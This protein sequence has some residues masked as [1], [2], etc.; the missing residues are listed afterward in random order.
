MASNK[1]KKAVNLSASVYTDKDGKHCAK[2]EFCT[3]HESD[4]IIMKK[5]IEGFTSDIDS[6][7]FFDGLIPTEEDVIFDGS[8]ER[9]NSYISY[10]DYDVELGKIYVYFVKTHLRPDCYT[11]PAAVKIKDP[12]IYWSF[13]KINKEI[14]SLK[15]FENVKTALVGETVNHRMLS[16]VYTGNPDNFIALIGAVHPGEAGAELCLSVFR[17]ILENNAEVL[18]KTGLVVLPSV[19]A[20]IRENV[21]KGTPWYLRKNV[22]GV[23][24][25][26]NFDSLWE[27]VAYGYGYASDDIRCPTYRGLYPN[28]E[29]E[30]KAVINLLETFQPKVVLSYHALASVTADSMY[31]AKAS[32]NDENYMQKAYKAATLYKEGFRNQLGIPLN[33]ILYHACTQGSLPSYAYDKNIIGFDV[34]IHDSGIEQFYDCLSD[35]TTREML[36]D[37]ISYHTSAVLNLMKNM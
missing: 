16:A 35:N 26:R 23:D 25:N 28:S 31:V 18:K 30:T 12:Y 6:A 21:A 4:V 19:N 37:C 34:E 27:E 5:E 33:R 3:Y 13:D 22:N 29:P 32:E 9:I 10:Y 17:N 1:T 2:V 36:A 14:E 24:L 11:G 8:L 20:D 15:N 7:E